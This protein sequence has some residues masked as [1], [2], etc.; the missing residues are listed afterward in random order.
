MKGM[1]RG[2]KVGPLKLNNDEKTVFHSL[3]KVFGKAPLLRHFDPQRKGQ[4]EVDA[5]K[6][7]MAGIYSQPDDQEK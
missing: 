1:T 2:K 6:K 4:V 7:G 5:C 3:L